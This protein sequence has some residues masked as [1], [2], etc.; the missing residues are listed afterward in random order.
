[1]K[2]KLMVKAFG[3]IKK[4]TIGNVPDEIQELNMSVPKLKET[5]VLV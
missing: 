2:T 3:L 4:P 5:E 1:M